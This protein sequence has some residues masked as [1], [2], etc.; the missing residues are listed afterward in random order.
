MGLPSTS[1]NWGLV[2][3]RL[4]PLLILLNVV[5][6]GIGWLAL[7]FLP[8]V[9]YAQAPFIFNRG[10]VNAASFAAPGLPNG[11]IARGSIFSIFGR[12][13]GPQTS[14][15][16]TFPLAT[17]LGGVSIKV[18]QGNA[19]V[20][21]IPLV[22]QA[23]QINALMPSNA[24]LG[25]ASLQVTFSGQKSN[26]QPVRIVST[27]FGIFTV[28]SGGVGPGVLQNFIS[29]SNQPVNSITQ[30]A[31]RGQ[32][33]TMWGTGLGAALGSDNQ[34]P[35]V[36]NLAAKTEVF[37]GGIPAGVSYHGRSPC[38]AGTDQVSFTVPANAPTGCWVPVLVRTEGI[39]TSNAATMAISSD[40]K[41]CSEPA[42]PVGAF[43]TRGGKMAAIL[44]MRQSVDENINVPN[45]IEASSDTVIGITAQVS[46]GA[47]PFHRIFS[48]PPAGSC[49]VATAPGTLT[50]DILTDKLGATS[51]LLDAGSAW[52][53]GRSPSQGNPPLTLTRVFKA[54]PFVGSAGGQVLG[55]G[56]LPAN[57]FLDPGS[58]QLGIPGGT[59]LPKMQATFTMPGALTWTGRNNLNSVDRSV[60]LTLSWTGAPSGSG[61]FVAGGN[62]DIPTNSS[63]A[64]FCSV[65]PGASSFTVPEFI[66]GAIPGTENLVTRSL[67]ALYVGAWNIANPAT[68]HS[69]SL[70]FGAVI[71]VVV[72]GKTVVFK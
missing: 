17:T 34:A 22:V 58:Y 39:H 11:S 25:L 65:P 52:T 20:D 56:G 60:P 28:N 29:T 18:T 66:L 48:L 41:P 42:N 51:K 1:R 33:I 19:S 30:T 31:K 59:D 40:G 62:I 38:C 9:A 37:V 13:L 12:S 64:F 68:F 70:D 27:N 63:A 21:V 57:L 23:G 35:S 15:A 2:N 47:F 26:P 49:T 10:V 16:Q 69:S 5:G 72:S 61:L 36:G 3:R 7:L 67:G 46:P 44:A 71:S 53:L 24:P 32:V 45:V 6:R 8:G 4:A 14:P 54:L 50:G 43:V 55:I